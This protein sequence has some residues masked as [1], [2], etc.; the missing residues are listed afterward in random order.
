MEVFALVRRFAALIGITDAPGQ[1]IRPI[2]FG[3]LDPENGTGRLSQKVG[4][5]NQPC[6]TS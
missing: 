3:M 1:P 4:N 2:F 5:T 6:V